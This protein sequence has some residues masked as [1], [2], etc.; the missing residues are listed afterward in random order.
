M[1][2]KIMANSANNPLFKHFRQ[3][4]IYIGLPSGGRYYGP[5]SLNLPITKEIPVYPMTVKDELTLKTPDALMNGVGMIDMIKSCCPNIID[6]WQIPAI[7]MDAIFIAIRLASYGPGMDITSTCPH[8]QIKNEFTI[9]LRSVLDKVKPVV[10]DDAVMID[11]LSFKFKPQ[12]YQDI[13]QTNII[14]FEQQRL[15]DSVIRNEELPEDEKMR[16]FN[17]SFAKLKDM[18]LRVVAN[19]IDSITTNE[20]VVVTDVNQIMEFLD[21]TGR[22][23]YN[24]I[25]DQVTELIDRIKMEAMSLTCPECQ[26]QYTNKLEF[27]QS[28]FFG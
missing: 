6:P 7:D 25:K 26:A 2:I 28:N 21:N 14:T 4:A 19:S 22:N 11:S 13:N 27:D 15:I 23:T 18:N 20:G 16:L 1:E 8:C 12:Q 9:D 24:T 3:P 10:Y 5:G 17:E